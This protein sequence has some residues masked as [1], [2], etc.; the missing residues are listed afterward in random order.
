[1]PS[2]DSKYSPEMGSRLPAR[3]KAKGERIYRNE[4]EDLDG[5]RADLFSDIESFHNRR[6]MRGVPVPTII[7]AM[8]CGSNVRG[9]SVVGRGMS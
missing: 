3:P 6:R 2:N 8:P 7:R 1:M 5:M 9:S 4:D